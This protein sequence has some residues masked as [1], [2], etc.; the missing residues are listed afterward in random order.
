MMSSVDTKGYIKYNLYVNKKKKTTSQHRLVANAFIPNPDNK[1]QVNHINGIKSDNRIDNLEWVTP[2]ENIKHSFDILNRSIQKHIGN[3]DLN[4]KK[5]AQYDLNGDLIKTFKS[6][7]EASIF[8]KMSACRISACANSIIEKGKNGNMYMC[9]SSN[10]FMFRFFESEPCVKINPYVISFNKGRSRPIKIFSLDGDFIKEF[11][12]VKHCAN[13]I[14]ITPS[15]LS[16]KL[17]KNINIIKKFI[18]KYS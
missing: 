8:N 12:T 13:Y 7:K 14:D 16:I 10:G 4:C 18:I 17:N 5:I 11:E 1:S 9:K 3:K 15:R 2:S 6:I